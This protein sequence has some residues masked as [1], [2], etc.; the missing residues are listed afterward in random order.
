MIAPNVVSIG[1]YESAY[2]HGQYI[3]PGTR[4][5]I[6]YSI[7]SARPFLVDVYYFLASSDFRVGHFIGPQLLEGVRATPY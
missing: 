2:G 5:R 4:S 6:T 1:A 7:I 3:F